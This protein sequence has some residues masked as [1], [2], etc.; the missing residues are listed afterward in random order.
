MVYPNAAV[1]RSVRGVGPILSLLIS[2]VEPFSSLGSRPPRPGWVVDR[3]VSKE[4][5][6]LR[7]SRRRQNQRK[8]ASMLK[9]TMLPITPPATATVEWIL[10][11]L[12]V[13]MLLAAPLTEEGEPDAGAVEMAVEVP[14]VSMVGKIAGDV[15]MSGITPSPVPLG[16]AVSCCVACV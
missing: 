3:G 9:P 7:P 16:T 13:G 1:K 6:R 2:Y 8:K 12:D 4:L 11:S 15:L 10:L 14:L 5:C